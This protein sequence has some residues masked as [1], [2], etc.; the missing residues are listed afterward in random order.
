MDNSSNNS[1]DNYHKSSSNEVTK[2]INH[3]NQEG[4][5]RRSSRVK[6]IPTPLT[7]IT[8]LV[9]YQIILYLLKLR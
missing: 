8:T 1:E 4:D 7:I 6:R 9:I 3:S 5:L 2:S